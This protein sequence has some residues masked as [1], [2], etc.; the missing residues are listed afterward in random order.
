MYTLNIYKPRN[1][2]KTMTHRTSPGTI[3]SLT[4]EK[5]KKNY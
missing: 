5:S 3:I 1:M 2:V 4:A